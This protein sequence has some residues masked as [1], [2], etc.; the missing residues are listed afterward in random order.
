MQVTTTTIEDTLKHYFGNSWDL[1]SSGIKDLIYKA[2][3]TND[4]QPDDI[5]GAECNDK[6]MVITTKGFLV[7]TP[8]FYG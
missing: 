2:I 5:K 1:I 7:F 4:I 3:D 6:I 8:A